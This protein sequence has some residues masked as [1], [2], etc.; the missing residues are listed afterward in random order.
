MSE[1][2]FIRY[3]DHLEDPRRDQG[4]RHRL[5][6]VL[7][8]AL[9]AVV[10]GAE[11]WDDIATFAQA[12]VS[13]LT[14]RLDLKH[15]T[16]SGDTF[17]RVLA[18]IC[19]E[20]FARGF[21]RWVE[22]LAQQTAGEVIAID[23]KT[24]RRSYDKD[25][26]KAALH[27]ISAWA[28]EQH[29]VLAQEKVSAKSNEITAI[30]ALLEVLDLEGCIVT[31]DAM[32]TQTEIAEAI[33][34]Q[35]ADYVLALKGN[36]GL[37]HREVR[38][39]FEQGRTRHWRA[40]PVAYAERCD[41]GHGRKEVRRLWISTDVAWVPKAEAWR[42]LNS[43]VMVEHERHTQQGVSLERRFY[44][45]S[46]ATTAEQMLDIIRSHWGIE[47][48]LHWVL[49]VVFREDESRIRRDHGGQNMAVVR[50]LALNL[51]RKD[52]TKR[53]SLRMKRKR[54]G[55]DDAFLAQIVGI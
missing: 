26:P 42:D 29:L 12:K 20:A 50:Q 13:W 8:I 24:L 38:A 15:G 7:V 1:T 32:G 33:C 30:P 14:Q 19:P 39:Y 2:C 48:Q 47:N 54:A 6:H 3:F 41:L 53:L 16:P 44:I 43:L 11:G 22:A 36:Q 37:L 55:W 46:L 45:S 51:L 10:A 21:V 27:M 18:A 17:R 9:C 52:E 25:D 34:A 49:D 5:E 40:M 35:G 4:K 23:G 28:C 31:L